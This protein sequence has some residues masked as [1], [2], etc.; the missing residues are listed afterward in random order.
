MNL[1]E[2]Y[3]LDSDEEDEEEVI[4][5]RRS[6][7]RDETRDDLPL[8][9]AALQELLS[10]VMKHPD[11]WAF[12]RPVQKNEVSFS[13]ILNNRTILKYCVDITGT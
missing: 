1:F 2:N 12:I 3:F 11:S 10:D 6:H 13:T 8:H 5:K 4:S 7:R 9:N